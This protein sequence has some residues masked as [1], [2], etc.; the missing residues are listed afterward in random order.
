MEDARPGQFVHLGP[1]TTPVDCAA[2]AS[3]GVLTFDATAPFLR[4]AFSIAGLRRTGEDACEVDVIYRVVGVATRWLSSLRVGDGVSVLG[5][6]GNAFPIRRTKAEAWLVA[7]GVGLPPMLWLAE[8]LRSADRRSVAFV[9]AR[10][11]ELLAVTIDDGA[12]VSSDASRA[13]PAAGEFAVWD[14]PVVISTDDGTM[15]YRGHA[16]GAMSAFFERSQPRVDDLVVYAC[17]PEVM[18]RAVARFCLARSIECHVC[19][20]RSMACGAGTCQSCVVAVHDDD[21]VDGWR[22]ALCCTQGPVFDASRVIWS[23]G[24]GGGVQH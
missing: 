14:V 18:M 19:M 10:S 3:G 24:A 2:A 21:A 22:Y 4:R 17:G 1:M 7:G 9:G 23:G 15:G 11:A 20:E 12:T 16:A 5:P 13:V 6:A 8:A